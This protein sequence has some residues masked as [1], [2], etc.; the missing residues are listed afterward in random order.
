M[1]NENKPQEIRKTNKRVPKHLEEVFY[2]TI[3]YFPE[4][5]ESYIIVV[6]SKFYGVQHTLRSYPPFLSLLNKRK[7][8][9]YPIAIN[10]NK[11]IPL[12]FYSL[13]REQQQ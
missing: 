12:S 4:L 11:D 8:R 6:E 5:K 9:V 1:K 3:A 13:T 10:T 7:D 2:K